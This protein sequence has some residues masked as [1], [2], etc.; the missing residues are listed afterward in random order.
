VQ[1]IVLV[2]G[3]GTRLRPLTSAV[4]KP[5]V[6]LVDRPFLA[7]AIEWLAAHGVTEIV[8]ACGFLPDVLRE[9]LGDEERHTGVTITY[10]AEPA[11]LGTAGAIRF[12][13]EALGE[14]L[15]D[16]FLALNGDVL[17]DLDLGALVRAHEKRGATATI[18]LHPVDD[19]SAYGLVRCGEEGQV[20][21]FLEKT[22]E[23]VPGE[24]NAGAYVLER[25]VLDLVP[26]GRAVSIER[27]VFPR[28]VDNGL[29]ALLLPGYWMDIGTPERYLQASWDIL[30]GRVETEVQPTSP[31]CL[32][33]EGAQVHAEAQL[34]KRAV[35]SAGCRIE[36]GAAV[37]ETILL[38]G[39]TVGAGARLEHSI[40][41]PGAT[42]D[43]G[44][45]LQNTV[46]GR[47]ERVP[48]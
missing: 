8:L 22:G 34:G 23:A 13:A 48:A 44:A 47:D 37:S 32:V 12:A 41:A 16:R 5:A 24:I 26:A 6:T 3:E 31:G 7:Y 30:E 2:G 9:A 42:V 20:L 33:A 29:C 38:D 35:V 4:P 36:A 21:E 11:P 28:L 40:L 17:A 39:C 18:G 45:Q 25:S 46:V 27:E 19:S 1:A 14:R 43:P 15:E 10:V